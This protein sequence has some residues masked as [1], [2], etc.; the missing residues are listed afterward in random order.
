MD[1]AGGGDGTGGVPSGL[2][3]DD[4]DL[5]GRAATVAF[6]NGGECHEEHRHDDQDKIKLDK[7]VKNTLAFKPL[8][9]RIFKVVISE[10]AGLN[11]DEI[12]A[13]IE[14]EVL[15]S[16]VYV[17]GGLSNSGERIEGLSTETYFNGEG[18]DKYDL[19]TYLHLPG[20]K[21]HEY[22]KLLINI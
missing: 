22:I 1:T 11:Y 12:E 2:T 19:R 18:L 10:C 13:C 8:L 21:D 9:A 14:G 20:S 6:E 17:D 15:I 3:V 16:T 4:K 7:A 5:V